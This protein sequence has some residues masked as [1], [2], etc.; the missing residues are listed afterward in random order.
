MQSEMWSLCENNLNS[1][2]FSSQSA[3]PS[4]SF[5][6]QQVAIKLKPVTEETTKQEKSVIKAAKK[7]KLKAKKS[8]SP[9]SKVVNATTFE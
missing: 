5:S 4:R 2:N 1:T 6:D 3:I 9:Q 8:P 7:I